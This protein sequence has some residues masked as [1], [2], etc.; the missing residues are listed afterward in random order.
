MRRRSPGVLL[1]CWLALSSACVEPHKLSLQQSQDLQW[2]EQHGRKR[3]A[4]DSATWPWLAAVLTSFPPGVGFLYLGQTGNALKTM[5]LFWTIVPWIWNP[6]AAYQEATYMNDVDF[7]ESARKARW[8][9][10][11]NEPA[12]PPSTTAP[13]PS[14]PA[15]GGAKPDGWNTPSWDAQPSG[16]SVAAPKFCSQCGARV[17]PP[18]NFCFQCGARLRY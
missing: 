11:T 10:A 14:A 5:F 7:L 3:D 1:A 18:G 13:T 6:I 8:F 2:L 12:K 15:N 4:F 17:A 9:D 16:S